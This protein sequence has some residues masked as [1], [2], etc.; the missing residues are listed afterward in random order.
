M[1]GVSGDAQGACILSPLYIICRNVPESYLGTQQNVIVG[2]SAHH[3]L[4]MILSGSLQ[5]PAISWHLWSASKQCLCEVRTPDSQ[6][7]STAPKSATVQCV[8]ESAVA[9][10]HVWLFH[11][12][13]IVQPLNIHT[14]SFITVCEQDAKAQIAKRGSRGCRMTECTMRMSWCAQE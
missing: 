8:P 3:S 6:C 5:N 11:A 12:T 13:G 1:R 7:T 10:P 4:C 2:L 14:I 9:M